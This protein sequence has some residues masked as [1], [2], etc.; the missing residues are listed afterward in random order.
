MII[1]TMDII[2]KRKSSI[3]TGKIYFWDSHYLSQSELTDL[4]NRL[5]VLFQLQ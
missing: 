2:N 4:N 1:L 5:K 3:E